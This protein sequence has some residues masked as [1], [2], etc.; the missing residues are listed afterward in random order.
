MICYGYVLPPKSRWLCVLIDWRQTARVY[1]T[2][3]WVIDIITV[4]T[5][6]KGS[7]STGEGEEGAINFAQFSLW[8]NHFHPCLSSIITSLITTLFLVFIFQGQSRTASQPAKH[9]YRKH[10]AN[11]VMFTLFFMFYSHFHLILNWMAGILFAFLLF[12]S[13]FYWGCC[14]CIYLLLKKCHTDIQASPSPPQCADLLAWNEARGFFI[15]LFHAFLPTEKGFWSGQW[16]VEKK[17]LGG[18]GKLPS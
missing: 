13:R 16:L 9:H 11:F 2:M 8:S 15:P 10:R 17:T 14:V 5:R 4:G 12:F 18:Y 6:C 1:E 3:R 7:E